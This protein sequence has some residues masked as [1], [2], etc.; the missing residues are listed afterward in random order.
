MAVPTEAELSQAIHSMLR[1]RAVESPADDAGL[2]TIWHR[3][4]RGAD[5]VTWVDTLGKVARQEL[6]LFADCF[7]WEK[8][9][10]L[11]TGEHQDVIGSKLNP[12][13][14]TI[15]FDREQD[16]GRLGRARNGLRPYAGNDKCILHMRYLVHQGAPEEALEG[17]TVSSPVRPR[18]PAPATGG[19]ARPALRRLWPLWV[20]A[21]LAAAA[22][23]AWLLLLK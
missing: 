13:P 8:G 19:A 18:A 4:A 7:V 3:G 10:G 21:G 14:G 11:R 6:Y 22:A 5:L 16:G 17:D 2:R 23:G 20:A 9:V 12:S 1:V 15:A